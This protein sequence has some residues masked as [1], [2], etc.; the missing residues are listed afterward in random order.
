MKL[1][2]NNM[3]QYKSNIKYS[4]PSAYSW[5]VEITPSE[6]ANDNNSKTNMNYYL[7]KLFY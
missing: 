3:A 2:Y 6:K 4:Q 7:N 1:K 5:A